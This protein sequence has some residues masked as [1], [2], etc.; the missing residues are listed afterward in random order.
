MIL[1]K[2]S[3]EESLI[4]LLDKEDQLILLTWANYLVLEKMS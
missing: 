4:N 2:W 3:R 1:A